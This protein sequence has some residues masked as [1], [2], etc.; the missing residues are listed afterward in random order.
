MTDRPAT[1]I[2][3]LILINSH[4][5]DGAMY[6]GALDARDLVCANDESISRHVIQ[7]I[8]IKLCEGKSLVWIIVRGGRELSWLLRCATLF[9]AL[10]KRCIRIVL[11]QI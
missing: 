5:I 3:T 4:E 1:M 10:T 8:S 6:L 9:L 7:D 11:P 2:L